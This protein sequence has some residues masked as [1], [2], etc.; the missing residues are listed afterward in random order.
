MHGSAILC[1]EEPLHLHV[2]MPAQDGGTLSSSSC[3]DLQQVVVSGC[4]VHIDEGRCCFLEL[5]ALC[6]HR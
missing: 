2:V 1:D 4:A 3:N 5:E 6:W